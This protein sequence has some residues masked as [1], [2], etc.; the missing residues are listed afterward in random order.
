[1]IVAIALILSV[2]H[3]KGE[4]ID[5]R[6]KSNSIHFTLKEPW[7]AGL[8][9][10]EVQSLVG[11]CDERGNRV[12]RYENQGF[13]FQSLDFIES[14]PIDTNLT[15]LLEGGFLVIIIELPIIAGFNSCEPKSI[16][17]DDH[18]MLTVSRGGDAFSSLKK[19]YYRFGNRIEIRLNYM[20]EMFQADV[21]ENHP[22]VEFPTSVIKGLHFPLPS[23]FG[24]RQKELSKKFLEYMT[25]LISGE[26]DF[27]A[28]PNRGFI[29]K[30]GEPLKFN[31]DTGV[32]Q[33]LKLQS[34]EL[35]VYA[36]AKVDSIQKAQYNFSTQKDELELEIVSPTL[37][38]R[39]L[40]SDLF[41]LFLSVIGFVSSLIGLFELL[42]MK[43][44][45]RRSVQAS[46][47]KN[48]KGQ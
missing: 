39:W 3:P 2:V 1:M 42:D 47:H 30:E 19:E 25:S 16:N 11:V 29:V 20:A 27:P 5:L 40:R 28:S 23:S 24:S 44:L 7:N 14:L 9:S 43:D 18:M 36:I 4:I 10:D 41:I 35:N 12:E 6:V 46:A 45:F 37:L 15:F 8:L 38:D 31:I 22:I 13:D 48:K 33:T 21:Q 17:D 26:V 34:N 32:L